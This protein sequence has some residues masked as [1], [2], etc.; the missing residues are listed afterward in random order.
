MKNGKILIL[1]MTAVCLLLILG[2]GCMEPVPE[3]ETQVNMPLSVSVTMDGQ[4]ENLRCWQ[5]E[6]GDYVVFLPAG[7]GMSD[8]VLSP[9][10][11]IRVTLEQTLLEEAWSCGHLQPETPYF[12]SCGTEGIVTE[13]TLTFLRSGQVPSLHLDVQSGN[14]EFIHE[15]CHHYARKFGSFYFDNLLFTG[16]PGLGKTFLS[17]AIAR[18]VA[19]KGYSVAYDTVS[20]VL[21]V[22]E[23]EKYPRGGEEEQ[24]ENASRL[25]QLMGCDLLILDDLGTEMLNAMSHNSLYTLLDGRIR[26]GKSTIIS[27]NLDRAAITER[28]GPQLSSRLS[29]EYQWLTFLARDIRLLRKE[30]G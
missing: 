15:V 27:T 22:F 18:V 28:Y 4:Q 1:L 14:M 17:A 19:E 10:E 2:I 11:G 9:E 16:A 6:K 12:L 29:G 5:D 23:R 13:H 30:R 21:T 20:A 7:V 3:P 25:R 26:A 24:A 8:V